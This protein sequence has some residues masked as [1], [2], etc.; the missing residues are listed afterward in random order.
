GL[1]TSWH[2][3]EFT[4]DG[5][6]HWIL[7]SDK[8]SGFY[9]MWKE[10]LDLETIPFHHHRYRVAVELHK[11]QDKYGNKIFY[12]YNN[13]DEFQNYMLDLA[14]EDEAVIKEYIS[15]VRKLQQFEMPP[16]MD[17]LPLIPSIVRGIKMSR[18][19]TL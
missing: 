9:H 19:L 17:E 5:C 16:V 13:L 3:G 2:K 4:V 1:C 18:Y 8:G 14:P 10:L 15:D 12:F 11:N 6:A 7:G